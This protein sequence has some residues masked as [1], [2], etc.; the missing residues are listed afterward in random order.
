MTSRL[1][2]LATVTCCLMAS[3]CGTTLHYQPL[4][5]SPRALLEVDP[6]AVTIFTTS[7][8]KRR[9][10]EVGLI[11]GQQTGAASFDDSTAVLNKMRREAGRR[12]CDGLVLLGSDDAVVGNQHLTTTLSGYRATCIVYTQD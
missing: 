8:P 12:G 7:K 5:T 6:D 1:L 2:R 11:E 4:N 10:V 9:F 3:A